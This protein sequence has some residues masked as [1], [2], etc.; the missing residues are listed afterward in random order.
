MISVKVR[1]E[2]SFNAVDVEMAENSEWSIGVSCHVNNDRTTAA[3]Q[4]DVAACLANISDDHFHAAPLSD[5]GS[6]RFNVL[7]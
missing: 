6:L 3:K 1:N 7:V 4:D 5:S 2:K